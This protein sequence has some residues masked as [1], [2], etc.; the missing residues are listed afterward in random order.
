[1]LESMR[2]RGQGDIFPGLSTLPFPLSMQRHKEY[3][4]LS[5][6]SPEHE[7]VV[8]FS[9]LDGLLIERNDL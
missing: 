7:K 4:Q 2:S 9:S 5:V 6:I 1:M 8:C 3:I